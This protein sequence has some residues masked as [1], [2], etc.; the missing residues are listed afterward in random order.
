[1]AAQP[2]PSVI[3]TKVRIQGYG[4]LSCWALG[5]DFRQDDGLRLPA[6]A[7]RCRRATV[8]RKISV[9]LPHDTRGYRRCEPALPASHQPAV[10]V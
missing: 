5:P 8:V 3:L 6:R 1:M 7:G 10:P 9:L 4:V 2:F